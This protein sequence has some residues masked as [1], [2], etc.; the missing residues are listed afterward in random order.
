MATMVAKDREVVKLLK[1]LIVLDLDAIEA[2]DAAVDRLATAGDRD[3]LVRFRQDHQRHVGELSELVRSFGEEPP[4]QADFR[5]I[6]TMGKVVLAGLLDDESILR[7]MKSN[8]DD[9]NQAYERAVAHTGLPERVLPVLRANL[10]DERR[11][12]A[13]IET[14]IETMK[15]QHAHP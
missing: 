12:R 1:E 2:Y 8:E 10:G 5:R 6:L 13:W 14:R 7:A 3:Q 4:G 9:T 15:A 11:H